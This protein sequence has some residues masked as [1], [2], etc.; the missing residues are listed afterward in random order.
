MNIVLQ[1]T[2]YIIYDSKNKK[3]FPNCALVYIVMPFLSITIAC[4]IIHRTYSHT[5]SYTLPTMTN[6]NHNSFNK[7]FNPNFSATSNMI[8]IRDDELESILHRQK[9]AIEI[10]A[11][12]ALH[13]KQNPNMNLSNCYHPSFIS[14]IATPSNMIIIPDD[15]DDEHE[16]I[17]L[18][19]KKQ[20]KEIS[21]FRRFHANHNPN[22]KMVALTS[23]MPFNKST[24]GIHA[25]SKIHKPMYN[26]RSFTGQRY[27]HGTH[28]I[29]ALMNLQ[30][31]QVLVTNYVMNNSQPTKR[32]M[33]YMEIIKME[34]AI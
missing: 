18:Q 26:S 34:M 9:R 11:L 7:F 21:A 31:S 30:P 24:L 27:G 33:G 1:V 25:K 10:M 14:K 32:E 15:D 23:C 2:E 5:T 12:G 22:T 29:P 4:T 20:A 6:Y 3:D 13:A 17:S 16:R 8:T 19:V 28:Q